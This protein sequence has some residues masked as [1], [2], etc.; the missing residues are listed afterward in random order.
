MPA[1]EQLGVVKPEG[2]VT[3]T[4]Y[5]LKA[6]ASVN[7]PAETV[8]G[9]IK[10]VPYGILC[11]VSS[12]PTWTTNY[13]SQPLFP[14][15]AEIDLFNPQNSAATLGNYQYQVQNPANDQIPAAVAPACYR[16]QIY[17]D[18]LRGNPYDYSGNKGT[19]YDLVPPAG[20][21]LFDAVTTYSATIVE[22]SFGLEGGKLDGIVFS[23][24]TKPEQS[25]AAFLG[26]PD[27]IVINARIV[28][29]QADCAGQASTG[30]YKYLTAIPAPTLP[31]I[32]A[33]LP[34]PA[35]IATSPCPA[36]VGGTVTAAAPGTAGG[37]TFTLG[38]N[39]TYVAN[40]SMP[41]CSCAD[42]AT[43]TFQ[44]GNVTTNAQLPVSV[45]LRAL[46]QNNYALDFNL[47]PQSL[48]FV[49]LTL[50]LPVFNS[51]TG[52][53]ETQSVTVYCPQDGTNDLTGAIG[54]IL[55]QLLELRAGIN[56]NPPDTTTGS[57]ASA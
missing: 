2:S 56:P 53:D 57:I 31:T 18:H 25:L 4:V 43:P 22:S 16:L 50:P 39:G 30:G 54:I 5:Y 47:P 27:D 3:P 28:C 36:I 45:K 24:P 51:A 52:Q 19:E 48:P 7:V 26:Y 15:N 23:D 32:P 20:R 42:G 10:M 38:A 12:T 1:S 11:P 55:A 44:V 8:D 29:Y 34:L 37:I 14:A 17:G 41:S 40:V 9:T 46:S 49:P 6:S 21:L 13:Q 33:T 35:A